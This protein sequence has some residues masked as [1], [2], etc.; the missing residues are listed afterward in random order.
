VL[1]NLAETT[2]VDSAGMGELVG[3]MAALEK[4]G[5][6]LKLSDVPEKVMALLEVANLRRVLDIHGHEAAALAS[7]AEKAAP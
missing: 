1:V 5:G 4:T 2:Y 7:F 3:A 6:Q